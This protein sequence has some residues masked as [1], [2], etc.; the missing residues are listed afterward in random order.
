MRGY[1]FQPMATVMEV[2]KPLA[3]QFYECGISWIAGCLIVKPDFRI[4]PRVMA[5]GCD[6]DMV[7]SDLVAP[8]ITPK[9]GC[10]DVSA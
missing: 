9:T 2:S 3:H 8:S 5:K 4:A 6:R 10:I 1:P 7:W